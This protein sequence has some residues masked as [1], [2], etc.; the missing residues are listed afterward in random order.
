LKVKF[1][2]A[3]NSNAKILE[4]T[5][6]MRKNRTKSVKLEITKQGQIQKNQ[7]INVQ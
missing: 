5:I 6:N 2:I 4:E 3:I 7:D 1:S